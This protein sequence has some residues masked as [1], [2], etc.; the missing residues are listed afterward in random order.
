MMD[1]LE[2]RLECF[3][4]E[5]EDCELIAKLSTDIHAR[6]RFAKLAGQLRAMARDVELD[7]EAKPEQTAA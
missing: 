1:D 3:L 4:L 6:A 7:I 2:A 5:A